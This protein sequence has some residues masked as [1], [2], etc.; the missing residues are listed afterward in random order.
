MTVVNTITKSFRIYYDYTT[1][2]FFSKNYKYL[3]GVKHIKL[4]DFTVKEKSRNKECH[5]KLLELI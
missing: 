1:T 2:L 5:L 3:K 4:K